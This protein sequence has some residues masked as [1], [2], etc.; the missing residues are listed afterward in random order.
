MKK[1]KLLLHICCAPCATAVFEKLKFNFEVTGFFYNPNIHPKSEYYLRLRN[2]KKLAKEVGMGLVVVES[3]VE[4]WFDLTSDL[5]KEPERGKRCEVCFMM[6][7]EKAARYARDHGYQYFATTLSI[8]P[9]KDIIKINKVGYVLGE[10]Y[11]IEFLDEDFGGEFQKSVV[12]SKK[13]DLY[14]QKYCG[15]AYSKL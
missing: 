10:K 8:S 3:D 6:R 14:R 7:L 1:Q 9:Y 4:K 2:I 13:Y 15:C 12:L 11:G 5:R